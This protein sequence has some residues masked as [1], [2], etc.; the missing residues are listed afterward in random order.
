[1]NDQVMISE[2]AIQYLRS[3]R[4]WVLFLAVLAFIG[5]AFMA[6]VSIF[7][8]AASALVP[9]D[10]KMPVFVFPLIGLLY[11]VLSSLVFLIPGIL[12][13]RYSGAIARIPFS[14]QTAL[15][16]ALARQRTIWK[17]MGIYMIV[18]LSLDVL[19]ILAA[20][21]IPFIVHGGIYHL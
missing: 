16:D 11:L 18:V 1:M 19:G 3:T 14:G 21:A 10:S 12:M 4:P 9:A 17:Y 8:F 7:M 5:T 20:I 6:L 13:M 2:T 15:E